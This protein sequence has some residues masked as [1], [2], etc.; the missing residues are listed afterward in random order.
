M[1]SLAKLAR[2]QPPWARRQTIRSW[3]PRSRPRVCALVAALALCASVPA[4]RAEAYQDTGET[5]PPTQEVVQPQAEAA[6]VQAPAFR[7]FLRAV[8]YTFTRGLFARENLVPAVIGSAA[9]ASFLPFDEEISDAIRGDA[10][11]LGDAGQALGGPVAF[12]SLTGGLLLAVP[13]VENAR[14]R[15]FVFSL[16]QGLVL[17]NTLL[18]SLKAA[19][20]RTRPNQE[21]DRSFPSG[22]TAN[23]FLLATVSSHYYGPKLGIPFYALA[24]LIGVSRLEKGKHYPSDVV[25]GATL[26]C[27]SARAAVRSAEHA[28][29][30]WRVV[31]TAGPSTMAVFVVFDPLAR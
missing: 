24:V 12:T 13:F 25:F 3:R 10:E 8:P 27:L 15:A 4:G 20:G 30:R 14:Y 2:R 22:H 1:E 26:G 16:T 23:T 11:D 18:V 21:N 17:N 5:A 31:P 6:E 9:T 7:D 19:A 28:A 29:R